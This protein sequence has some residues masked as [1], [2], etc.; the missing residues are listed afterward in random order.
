MN[1]NFKKKYGQ[2]FI[3]DTNLLKKIVSLADLKEDDFV[4]EIGV[5]SGN[6]TAAILSQSKNY[7]GFE[8]DLSLREDLQNRFNQVRIV[9]GDF[10]K[11]DLSQLRNQSEISIIANLP[12]YITTPIIMRCLDSN[13]PIKQMIIMVQKEVADRF[14]AN[15]GTKDYNAL[16]VILQTFF[17]VKQEIQVNKKMFI[18]PPQVDSTVVSLKRKKL[19]IDI[20]K[21]KAFIKS[22]FRQKRKLLKNNVGKEIY[23][24][25]KEQL[26]ELGYSE[27][28]RAEEISIED[29]YLLF[30]K[31]N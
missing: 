3:H 1:H 26:T 16:S 7:L 13:L 31:I 15:Y 27:K 2:N 19:D 25:I 10:M 4:L 21:F 11:E 22:C 29:F 5:G 28:V 17:T 20:E 23:E 30:E 14:T 9:Y 24:Q 8:I 18:P 6:L 12:Y